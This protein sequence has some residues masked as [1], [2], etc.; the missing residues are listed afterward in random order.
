MLYIEF[1]QLDRIDMRC[2]PHLWA[3]HLNLDLAPLQANSYAM[4]KALEA[5]CQAVP[6]N[7]A[8]LDLHAGGVQLPFPGRISKLQELTCH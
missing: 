7:S 4:A 8:V 6:A 5:I 2:W 3:L 1:A